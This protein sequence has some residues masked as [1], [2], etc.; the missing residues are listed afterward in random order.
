M[1]ST[2]LAAAGQAATPQLLH[3]TLDTMDLL[4]ARL[5]GAGGSRPR[6]AVVDSELLCQVSAQAE[7][8]ARRGV[9]GTRD[10]GHLVSALK[11]RFFRGPGGLHWV[12]C[13][14]G[15]VAGLCAC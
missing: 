14:L 1:L 10:A 11:A 5:Q 2:E 8:L 9:R 15:D 12:P 4:Q 3:H 13:G 7:E 6:E